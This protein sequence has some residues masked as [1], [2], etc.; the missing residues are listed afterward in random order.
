M[1][2]CRDVD[3]VLELLILSEEFLLSASHQLTL[4]TSLPFVHTALAPTDR[5]I[6]RIIQTHA[7]IVINIV[8]LDAV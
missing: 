4:I 8:Q 7:L 5:V 3:R 2:L 6:R 1:N